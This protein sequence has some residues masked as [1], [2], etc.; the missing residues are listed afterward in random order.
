MEIH[1][2]LQ[3]GHVTKFAQNDP[4]IAREILEAVHPT[5][6]LSAPQFLIGSDH[7]L[8]AFQPHLIVRVDLITDLDPNWP[9]SSGALN[10]VEITQDEFETRCHPDRD[11][12]RLPS[13][14]LVVFGVW[15]MVNGERVYLQTQHGV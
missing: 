7:V 2:Y 4:V 3:D 14:E 6:L 11:V 1:V 5:R 10:S 8:T 15:E 13:Q 9:L 12:Q